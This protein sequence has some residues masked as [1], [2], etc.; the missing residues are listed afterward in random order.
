MSVVTRKT[1]LRPRK[2]NATRHASPR[3]VNLKTLLWPIAKRLPVY[4]KLAWALVREPAIPRRH[5]ALLYGAALYTL[6]PA[7]LFVQPI[8][9]VG[10]VDNLALF[11][12]GLTQALHHCPPDIAAQHYTRLHLP[13][14]QLQDDLQTMKQ[15]IGYGV[16]KIGKPLLLH[17]RFAGRVAGGLGRRAVRRVVLAQARRA[18]RKSCR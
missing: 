16:S 7:H 11:L 10:Q 14:T 1:I 17:A 12:L 4:A 8:P 18:V 13:P 6:S 5:K 2:S 15:A 3:N 9:L